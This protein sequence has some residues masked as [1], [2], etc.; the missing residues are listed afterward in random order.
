MSRKTL[1]KIAALLET[2]RV[3][4]PGL[5]P[6][7][8]LNIKPGD[9]ALRFFVVV[10]IGADSYNVAGDNGKVKLYQNAD[11]AVKALAKYLPTNSGDYALTVST[12][13]ELVASLPADLKKDAAAKVIKFGTVK[14][15]QQAVVTGLDA[16][17]ALMAGWNVGNALQ[18]AR[19]AEVTDQKAAVVEDIAAIDGLIAHYT[20]IANS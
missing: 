19:F 12:G 9:K 20:A 14:T 17:L 15:A 18:Q 13:L 16:E 10:K 7:V 5:V 11:D 8:T 6:E 3:A 4:T 2:A 1:R